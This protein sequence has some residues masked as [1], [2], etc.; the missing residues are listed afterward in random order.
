MKPETGLCKEIRWLRS[1][2]KLNKGPTPRDE[3]A[4]GRRWWKTPLGWKAGGFGY[5]YRRTLIGM[6]DRSELLQPD[7]LPPPNDL[8]KSLPVP[9]SPI[10]S[11]RP[12]Q[13]PPEL[14][15]GTRLGLPA[16]HLRN[17]H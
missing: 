3:R 10:P 7:L 15:E 14:E 9:P 13:R 2:N 17:T 5:A 4:V 11:S 6:P 8:Y 12:P 16:R 1:L